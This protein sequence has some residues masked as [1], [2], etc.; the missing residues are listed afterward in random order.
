MSSP[1]NPLTNSE[2]VEK[3]RFL[4]RIMIAAF[5]VTLV[6]SA[7][8]GKLIYL[9][10]YKH[11]YY[12]ERAQRHHTRTEKITPM[13][14]SIYTSRGTP[15]ATSSFPQTA[16]LAPYHIP[17]DEILQKGL[18]L[19]L[20][21]LLDIPY[22]KA[23]SKVQRKSDV[24]LK[25]RIPEEVVNKL[26]S[27]R[28]ELGLPSNAIYTFKEGNR[29]YPQGTLAA[30]LVGFTKP[31]DYGDN[32]GVAGAERAFDEEIAGQYGKEKVET[33]V[34]G[35]TLT[36]LAEEAWRKAS[37][38][39][40]Y[41]TIDDA[42]QEYTEQ[43][44]REQ[45]RE[46]EARA[47]VCIVMEVG[48]GAVLA[49]ASEPTFDPANPGL[50][51]RENRTDRCLLHAIPPGSV[52]KTFTLASLIEQ[53]LVSPYEEIDCENGIYYFRNSRGRAIRTIKDTHRSE[54][55]PVHQAFAESS[56]VAFT[57]LGL[58]MKREDF[59]ARLYRFGFGRKTGIEIPGEG[60]GIMHPAHKWS[61]Q[62]Q[63]SVS[64]GYEIIVTPLQVA[65]AMAAIANDGI[66]VK[67]RLLNEIRSPANEIIHRA[68][69]EIIGR[70]CSPQTSRIVLNMLEEVVHSEHGTGEAARVP[71]YRIGGK[72]GTTRKHHGSVDDPEKP[73]YYASFL[74]V[75]PV[76][77][78]RVVIYT[79]VDEPKVKWASAS[80]AP[81][82]GRVAQHVVRVLGIP[83]TEP[84]E[85]EAPPEIPAPAAE[86][87]VAEEDVAKP[88]LPEALPGEKIMP[89][90]HGMTIREV[91]EKLNTMQI[92]AKMI[93]SGVAVRQ[94][95]LPHHPMNGAERGLVIF[96]RITQ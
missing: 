80:A 55:V 56:N 17:S 46:T 40:V 51:P 2:S 33:T 54:V 70:V 49:M 32:I 50:Y 88:A 74:A 43:A 13:R 29:I 85:H 36:P 4:H 69:P 77:N 84:R 57:K 28:E 38:N 47:G 10:Y 18:A 93:G 83:E 7:I 64:I 79:W 62:S 6:F 68:Q 59:Y 23:L 58:R 90:L 44:L 67:P 73:G 12:V 16:Y 53:N 52:M 21:K 14:G 45:V 95:P 66:Y 30:H 48:T 61:I 20:S 71:G 72:T 86:V 9:Q 96:D 35:L 65:A 82:C 22:E 63:I 75:V 60:A 11:D 3:R 94:Q 42:I 81:I 37:G 24:V 39:N 19:R 31:D 76:Q 34:G 27:I 87:L 26:N 92:D 78:P 91:A 15:L 41:L 8:V 89:D 5:G 25:R 1:V